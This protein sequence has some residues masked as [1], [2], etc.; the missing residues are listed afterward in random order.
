MHPIRR[1]Q[2][3]EILFLI[4]MS[5]AG[6]ASLSSGL[7]MPTPQWEVIGSGA[8]PRALGA[9]ALVLAALKAVSVIRAGEP[10]PLEGG[11]GFY[12]IGRVALSF[13]VM[14]IYTVSLSWRV[15]PFA[16]TSAVFCF[17]FFVV[18]SG[19]RRPGRLLLAA[20]VSTGFAVAV[21]LIFTR[22]FYID[23]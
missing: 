9:L 11:R 22:F 3:P 8:F 16:A 2:A 4:L 18:L 7:A 21:Q 10:A 14:S 5:V 15:L 19:E 13:A 1:Q 23:I 20:A 17:V 12:G 6:G